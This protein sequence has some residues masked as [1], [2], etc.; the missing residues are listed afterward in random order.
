MASQAGQL[1]DEIVRA[2]LTRPI[3]ERA[4]F[5]TVA[6]AG[7]AILQ[8]E[9]ERLLRYYE[10]PTSHS[11]SLLNS[12]SKQKRVPTTSS[13]IPQIPSALKASAES[14]QLNVPTVRVDEAD[15]P[16]ALRQAIATPPAAPVEPLALD[17]SGSLDWLTRLTHEPVPPPIKPEETSPAAPPAPPEKTNKGNMFE[18]PTV[19]P[20]KPKQTFDHGSP[21]EQLFKRVTLSPAGSASGSFS[22]SPSPARSAASI[23]PPAPEVSVSGTEI[24]Q[25][26]TYQAKSEPYQTT[27]TPSYQTTITPSPTTPPSQSAPPPAA[28]PGGVPFTAAN[29]QQAASHVME[30]FTTSA[31]TLDGRMLGPY[32][33]LYEIGRGG[34]GRVYLAED[35]RLGRRIALKLLLRSSTRSPERVRRFE[36]EARAASSLN[37]PNI[38]TIHEIGEIKGVH[39]LATEFVEGF[40]LRQVIEHRNLTLTKILDVAIQIADA[41]AAAHN[42][43]IV[44]RDIKPEN[45]MMRLDGYVKVLD[46]GVAKLIERNTPSAELPSTQ[47][48]DTQPGTVIGTADYMSPEQARGIRVDHRTDL[49]SLGIILYEMITGVRPFV[50]ATPTDVIAALLTREP[51]PITQR[52]SGVPEALHRIIKRALQKEREHR[53][54]SARELAH[55]LKVLKQDLELN[56]RGTTPRPIDRPTD[57][58][59]QRPAQTAAP[60]ATQPPAQAAGHPPMHASWQPQPSQKMPAPS[61]PQAQQ[62]P[63]VMPPAERRRT[64]Q[65]AQTGAVRA[66]TK[67]RSGEGKWWPWVLLLFAMTG[68]GIGIWANYFRTPDNLV[69]A[70]MPFSAQHLSGG[71][72]PLSQEDEEVLRLSLSE[73]LHESLMQRL[74]V[75]PKLRLIA[76]NSVRN[77]N[78]KLAVS[79][80]AGYLNARYVLTGRLVTRGSAVTVSLE[81]FDGETGKSAWSQRYERTLSDLHTLPESLSAGVAEALD[82]RPNAV[83]TARLARRETTN[84]QAF[85]DYLKGR[86]LWQQRQTES[87]KSSLNYLRNAVSLDAN[88]ARAHAAL[89]ESYALAPLFNLMPPTEAAQAARA[90]TGKALILDA[91]LAEAH[92]AQGFIAH[93]YEWNFTAAEKSFQR[94][95]ELNPNYVAAQQEYGSLLS[96]LGRHEEGLRLA[97]AARDLDPLSSASQTNVSAA[98]YFAARYQ[99][100]VDDCLGTI[101]FNPKAAGALKYLGLAY[102]QMS[103]MPDALEAMQRA[104]TLEPANLEL[105]AQLACIEADAGKSAEAQARL[106]ELRK[107][108]VPQYRLAT[109]HAALGDKEQA[110]AALTQAVDKHEPGVVWLK[111][112]PQMNLLRND[113]RFKELLKQ[114]G[115]P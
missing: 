86:Y 72:T 67:P 7:D 77:L 114:I 91:Q 68:L 73:G 56:A 35:K 29:S 65:P 58:P 11:G 82:L 4:A 17:E 113:Q 47:P 15:L 38:L 107:Q 12:P 80:V 69:V 104:A 32:Q 2:A 21:F 78:K 95:L 64:A 22:E 28:Q 83:Q 51:I 20:G 106:A 81:L 110:I 37:H 89:A 111:V 10:D 115:L 24:L 27:I 103:R 92:R 5:L 61:R 30:G 93:Q 46:F 90:A 100:T 85:T 75:L 1:A 109:L 57:R 108:A 74:G 43:N 44:H 31:R 60:R 99:Q 19:K 97:Q 34:M 18:S 42:A 9:V 33:L 13:R 79:E 70:L 41:L 63:P 101:E 62:A 14:S 50:G 105:T 66:R 23:E 36:Q 3:H 45:L 76:R 48:F 71:A 94:A 59:T 26:E 39:Y 87:L 98:H 54:E 52:L 84:A 102:Q 88:F 6:C 25:P 112:D 53:Y 96:S 8:G 49:F 16:E 55:D 40:T